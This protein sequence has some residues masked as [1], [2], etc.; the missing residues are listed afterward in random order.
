MNGGWHSIWCPFLVCFLYQTPSL[1]LKFPHN[2]LKTSNLR[3]Q[4]DSSKSIWAPVQKWKA[5]GFVHGL[6]AL[7]GEIPELWGE[8]SP[9]AP[10][11]IAPKLKPKTIYILRKHQQVR[12]FSLPNPFFGQHAQLVRDTAERPHPDCSSQWGAVPPLPQSSS[13]DGVRPSRKSRHLGWH[14]QTGRHSSWFSG[15]D[16]LLK[17]RNHFFLCSSTEKF[18]LLSPA[19]FTWAWVLILVLL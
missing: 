11:S 18:K 15:Y 10:S 17:S 14:R 9:S 5:R 12:L 13:G 3:G 2:F 16:L 19:L 1:L 7:P 4:G 6:H 8:S